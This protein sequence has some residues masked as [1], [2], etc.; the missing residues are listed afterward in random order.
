M[1]NVFS[2][3][4]LP[5]SE[6]N[7]SLDTKFEAIIKVDEEAGWSSDVVRRWLSI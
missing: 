1:V 5:A 4:S 6:G 7:S 2:I 3:L